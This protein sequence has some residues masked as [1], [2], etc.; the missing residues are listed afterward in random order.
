M[1]ENP[2]VRSNSFHSSLVN[3]FTWT[4]CCCR[5]FAYRS[6]WKELLLTR[7]IRPK[8]NAGKPGGEK[9]LFPFF[10]GEQI[11]VDQLLLSNFR[12]QIGMER[13]ASHPRDK[14]EIQCRKTRW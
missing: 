4:S 14:A 11:H 9:Q 2:V 7:E 12:I 5:T 3:R 13:V 10:F 1:P 8:F 6:E